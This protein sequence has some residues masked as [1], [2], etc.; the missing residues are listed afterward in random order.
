[1]LLVVPMLTACLSFEQAGNRWQ[2]FVLENQDCDVAEDCAIVYPGC[3]LDCATPIRAEALD[4][5][6]NVADRLI[7]RYELP[8]RMCA[9]DCVAFDDPICDAG[10]CALG[11]PETF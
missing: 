5:A 3:P 10:V 8:G 7:R 11:E 2:D 9:F 6:E 1:M 4:E